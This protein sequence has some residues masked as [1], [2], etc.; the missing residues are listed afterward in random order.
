MLLFTHAK[1]P[2]LDIL[3]YIRSIQGVHSPIKESKVQGI[4]IV[5][6]DAMVSCQAFK[7]AKYSGAVTRHLALINQV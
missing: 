6:I 7:V 5:H 1:K 2:Y 4:I 3:Y